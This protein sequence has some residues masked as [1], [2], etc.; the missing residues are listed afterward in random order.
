MNGGAMSLKGNRNSSTG[1][2]PLP[3]YERNCV[4]IRLLETAKE[5]FREG[6]KFYEQNAAGLGD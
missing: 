5:D 2:Q 6:W 4:E 1:I 3:T